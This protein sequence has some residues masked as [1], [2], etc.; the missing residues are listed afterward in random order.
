MNMKTKILAA[1]LLATLP[2]LAMAQMR[3]VDPSLKVA[4]VS[5]Q[6]IGFSSGPIVGGTVV[7]AFQPGIMNGLTTYVL[8][9]VPANGNVFGPNEQYVA[10]TSTVAGTLKNLYVTEVLLIGGPAVPLTA[11]YTWRI[12]GVSTGI[13]C[14]IVTPAT[15]CSDLVHTAPI[16][17]RQS[18][19][20]QTVG[21]GNN[22]N[23]GGPVYGGIELDTP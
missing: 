15:T 2:T 3:N 1:I 21:V 16:V 10:Q 4:P 17:A 23:N 7:T 12:N 8:N 6:T 14:T 5:K 22:G 11:T 19:D 13:T 9:G 20:L 18:Y